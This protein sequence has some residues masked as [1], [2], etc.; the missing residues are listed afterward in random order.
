MYVLAALMPEPRGGCMTNAKIFADLRM[1][2]ICAHLV[3]G[4]QNCGALSIKLRTNYSWVVCAME[5]PVGRT[6][7]PW[8]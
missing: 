2:E 1:T 4:R 5:L 6:A 7:L 8:A 3:K